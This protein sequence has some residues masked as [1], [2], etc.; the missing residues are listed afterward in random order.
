MTRVVHVPLKQLTPENVEG[1]GEVIRSLDE[2]EPVVREGEMVTERMEML[3][4]GD[5]LYFANL[6]VGDE[7][8]VAT[9]VEGAAHV[10]EVNFHSDATQA[11][12]GADR[13][14]TVFLLAKPT[15]NLRPENF[16]AFYSD[17]SLGMSMLPDV[18]HTSPLPVEGNQS[19]EN[20]QGNGYHHATVGHDFLDEDVVLEVPLHAPEHG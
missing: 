19:Y 3:R 7:G 9:L 10:S 16:V 8:V 20:T 1:F 2:V 5:E 4:K 6:A 14:P 12:I 11:F 15:N 18:W 13:K 17:G